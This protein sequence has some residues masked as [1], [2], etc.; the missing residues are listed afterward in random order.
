VL[1]II[2]DVLRDRLGFCGSL[3]AP[4]LVFDLV[5]QVFAYVTISR[6]STAVG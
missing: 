4:P 2:D 3:A 6:T 5:P 1:R